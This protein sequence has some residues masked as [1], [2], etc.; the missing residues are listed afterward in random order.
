VMLVLGGSCMG[1]GAVSRNGAGLGVYFGLV[2]CW[3][4]DKVWCAGRGY[5]DAGAVTRS[6]AGAGGWFLCGAMAATRSGAGAGIC[7]KLLWS[8]I[9]EGLDGCWG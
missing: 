9:W 4:G 3:G 5:F 6:G 7:A 1:A 8:I 2:W